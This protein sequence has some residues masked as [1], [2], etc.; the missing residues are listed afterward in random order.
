MHGGDHLRWAAD[1]VDG[2]VEIFDEFFEHGFVDGAGLAFPRVRGFFRL[3]HGGDEVEVGVF[4]LCL[5]EVVEED[6]VFGAAVGVE[7]DEFLGEFGSCCFEDHAADGCDA[8]ASGDEDGWSAVFFVEGELAPGG[9]E[10]ELGAEGDGF[11]GALEG[12]VAHAGGDH[13]VVFVGSA[14]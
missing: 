6:G 4:F 11:E 7:E 1:V 14:G 5:G 13:E 9:F 10:R 8:D 2:Y 3:G 12:G